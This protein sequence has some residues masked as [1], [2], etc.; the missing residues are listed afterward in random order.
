VSYTYDHF[1]A[2]QGGWSIEE[3]LVRLTGLDNVLCAESPR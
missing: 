1:Q 3:P 2:P